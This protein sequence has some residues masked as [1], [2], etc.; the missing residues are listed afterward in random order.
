MQFLRELGSF[1][2]PV[3][4]ISP[5]CNPFQHRPQ[6]T[7]DV[8]ASRD[9]VLNRIERFLQRLEIYTGIT[10]ITAIT[11]MIVEIMVEVL[12]ILMIATKEVWT[13]Q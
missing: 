5:L 4:C 10:P 1:F 9:K 12:T 3:P 8:S 13:F 7:K 6:V 11:D 2:W